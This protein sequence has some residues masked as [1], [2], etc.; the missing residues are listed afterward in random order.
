MRQQ[1]LAVP[2]RGCELVHLSR[3][4]DVVCFFTPWSRQIDQL[5]ETGEQERTAQISLRRVW[6]SLGGACCRWMPIMTAKSDLNDRLNRRR[7][8]KIHRNSGV[9]ES[10][11]SSFR[12]RQAVFT[13]EGQRPPP[14]TTTGRYW[15]GV[16]VKVPLVTSLRCRYGFAC[17]I[18]NSH[19]D[20]MDVLDNLYLT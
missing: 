11:S 20:C 2:W 9:V 3:Y 16:I 8:K 14:I 12:G 4:A 19:V 5:T 10:Y 15:M 1:G 6:R 18:M 7:C 17:T 13:R